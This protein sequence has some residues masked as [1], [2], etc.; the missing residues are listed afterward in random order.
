[1]AITTPPEH[2]DVLTVDA[3]LLILARCSRATFSSSVF[4]LTTLRKDPAEY[5]GVKREGL[6]K[7][8]HYR[9]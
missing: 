1:M 3:G 4:R 5:I 7:P 2:L 8:D 6:I 9:Y